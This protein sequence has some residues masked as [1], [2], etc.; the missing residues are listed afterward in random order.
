MKTTLPTLSNK[1]PQ[2]FD[3]LCEE[4][5]K[6]LPNTLKQETNTK[7]P[8]EI[9][10]S[11]SESLLLDRIP[12]LLEKVLKEKPHIKKSLS[13]YRSLSP[14]HVRFQ[15]EKGKISSF[16]TLICAGSDPK[17]MHFLRTPA[18][19]CLLGKRS[20]FSSDTPQRAGLLPH[21]LS[22]S[23]SKLPSLSRNRLALRSDL[24]LKPRLNDS[25][26]S[27]DFKAQHFLSSQKSRP[28]QKSVES[29]LFI[30][31]SPVKAVKSIK[32]TKSIHSIGERESKI[33]HILCLP[34]Q[35][36][37]SPRTP[38][39]KPKSLSLG[40]HGWFEQLCRQ[41]SFPLSPPYEITCQVSPKKHDKSYIDFPHFSNLKTIYS[42]T[43]SETE[44]QEILPFNRSP[45]F[46][47]KLSSSGDSPIMNPAS[48]VN[49]EASSVSSLR[50]QHFDSVGHSSTK[51]DSQVQ[52]LNP[53][54]CS[55]IRG[56]F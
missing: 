17:N 56:F 7:K 28:F 12:K 46:L 29:P 19:T 43:E 2:D 4:K 20:R 8:N 38:Q 41:N 21:K 44:H 18:K 53:N 55:Q 50:P 31:S 49:D 23:A 6:Q 34:S 40:E 54:V 1:I 39:K 32:T 14:N 3:I 25:R 36:I 24:K 5:T 11:D 10:W 15:N 51:S 33:S 27:K 16:R 9:T 37:H 42:Q 30:Y 26:I 45:K 13:L 47:M 22:F 35:E 48:T 52:I